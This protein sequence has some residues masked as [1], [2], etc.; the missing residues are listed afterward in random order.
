MTPSTD[1]PQTPDDG[2]GSRVERLSSSLD[3]RLTTPAWLARVSALGLCVSS[4]GFVA[5]VV[6]GFAIEGELAIV[7]TP[8]PL[9]LALWLPPFVAAFAAGTLAGAVVGWY[10]RYWSFPVRIHQTILAALG[11]LFVWQLFAHG[12]L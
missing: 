12:F 11:V 8:L 5:L 6:A 7:T 9:R 3:R 2:T 10:D 4:L 1:R